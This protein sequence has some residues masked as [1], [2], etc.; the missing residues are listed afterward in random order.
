ME[1]RDKVLVKATGG[2]SSQFPMERRDK[3]LVEATGGPSSQFGYAT[4][5]PLALRANLVTKGQ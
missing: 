3:V 1:R 5:P 2:P 4:P